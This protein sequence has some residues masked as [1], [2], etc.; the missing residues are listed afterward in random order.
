MYCGGMSIRFSYKN[1]RFSSKVLLASVVAVAVAMNA[2]L[3]KADDCNKN[4]NPSQNGAGEREVK[5]VESSPSVAAKPTPEP[6]L[7]EPIGTTPSS[8][9]K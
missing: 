4:N 7:P 6:K 8:Q 2:G 5:K 9:V 1:E 3:V